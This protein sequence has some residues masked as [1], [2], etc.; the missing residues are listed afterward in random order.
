LAW[1]LSRYGSLI[2]GVSESL[3]PTCG[4]E[5]WNYF[6]VDRISIAFVIYHSLLLLLTIGIKSSKDLRSPIHNGFWPI[7]FVIWAGLIV[8]TFYFPI[9]AFYNYWVATF[10]F[11]TF[12]IVLQAMLLVDFAWLWAQKWVALMETEENGIVYQVLL[13]CSTFLFYGIVIAMS[14]LLYVY[15]TDGSG[16]GLNIF[17]IT[18][19]IIFCFIMSVISILPKVQAVNPRSGIFQS[20]ILSVYSTYLIGSAIGAQ[21]ND[22]SFACT[23]SV[24]QARDDVWTRFITVVGIFITFLVLTYSATNLGSQSDSF[25]GPSNNFEEDESEHT[26]YNYSWFHFVYI[27]AMMYVTAVITD[28]ETVYELSSDNY[29]IDSGYTAMWIKVVTSWICNC[30]YIWT[31]VAPI[32]FPDRDFG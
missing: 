30:L 2:P 1:A 10:V 6:A 26:V 14:V 4:K 20:A 29:K 27:S 32:I 15:F 3:T 5:C 16:C 12:F 23:A 21:P 17:F 8:S 22:G 9:S 7:K 11:S 25:L 31:L 13:L 24:F 18:F 28:W 19:N